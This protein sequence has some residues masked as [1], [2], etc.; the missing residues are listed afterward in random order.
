[1]TFQLL[2][3]GPS[4]RIYSENIIQKNTPKNTLLPPPPPP[5]PKKGKERKINWVIGNS[6]F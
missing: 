1:M 2:L 6:D 5:P 4:L 3:T